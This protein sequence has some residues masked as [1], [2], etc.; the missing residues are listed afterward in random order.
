MKWAN[1]KN[2]LFLRI[3]CLASKLLYMPS[4]TVHIWACYK[5]RHLLG[6]VGML[7]R[8]AMRSCQCKFAHKGNSHTGSHLC[9]SVVWEREPT[10]LLCCFW[11]CFSGFPASR[12]CMN[13][14]HCKAFTWQW[15]DTQDVRVRVPLQKECNAI[16][17]VLLFLLAFTQTLTMWWQ[18]ELLLLHLLKI[19]PLCS[20][21]WDWPLGIQRL[22]IMLLW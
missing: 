1:R 3:H 5:N 14:V 17:D 6:S 18:S 13:N 19:Q 10:F 7:Y 8:G 12:T 4:F 22:S 20:P 21:S 15:T 11:F 9:C 16:S 2:K